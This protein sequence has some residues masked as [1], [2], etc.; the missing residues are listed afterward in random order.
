MNEGERPTRDDVQKEAAFPRDSIEFNRIVNLTDAVVAIALTLMVLQLKVDAPSLNSPESEAHLT[1]LIDEQVPALFAYA[2]SFAIIASCWYSHHRFM[3][4]LR[5]LDAVMVAWNFVYLFVLALV[6]VASDL[7]GN[8]SGIPRSD[9]IYAGVMGMLYL[10]AI[11]GQLLARSRGLMAEH[12]T[13]P[14]RRS[15][16]IT[17][18]I[19]PICFFLSIP[20]ILI[21][22]SHG[23]WLWIAIFP[24]G[25]GSERYRARVDAAAAATVIRADSAA[26]CDE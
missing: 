6:P 19:A 9:A 5:G 25:F 23:W 22:F 7:I 14:Q 18:A 20:F 4:Q 10:M 13:W 11:P 15:L 16:L 8:Y 3:A 1:A 24:L 17:M 21:G 2:L 26:V 12:Q